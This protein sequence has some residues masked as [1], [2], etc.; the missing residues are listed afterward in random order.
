MEDRFRLI[1]VDVTA[2]ESALAGRLDIKPMNRAYALAALETHATAW[3]RPVA[4]ETLEV[5]VQPVPHVWAEAYSQPLDAP[6]T[7]AESRLHGGD[8]SWP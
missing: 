8:G 1:A 6:A 4:P 7:P 2:Y 5:A 3:N